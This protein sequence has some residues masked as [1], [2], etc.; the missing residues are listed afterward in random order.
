MSSLAGSL[1]VISVFPGGISLRGAT[2]FL[3]RSE[4]TGLD[5][6][7][8]PIRLVFRGFAEVQSPFF[9]NALRR[10]VREIRMSTAWFILTGYS[11]LAGMIADAGV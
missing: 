7:G 10:F 9:P 6:S 3:E 4:K 1:L 2:T 11:F 8:P 5:L